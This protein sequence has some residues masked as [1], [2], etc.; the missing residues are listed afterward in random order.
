MFGTIVTK[1]GG[2][3]HVW[4]YLTEYRDAPL[5]E[6]KKTI[7][8]REPAK[9]NGNCMQCHSTEDALWR[10]VPDHRASLEDERAGRV[11]CASEGC[12]GLAHPFFRGPGDGGAP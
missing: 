10:K 6:A 5:E 3:R 8:L 7:R 2:M 9:M 4:M 11:A 1:A 12:H